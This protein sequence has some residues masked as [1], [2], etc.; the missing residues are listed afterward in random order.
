MNMHGII[1]PVELGAPTRVPWGRRALAWFHDAHWQGPR[2]GPETILEVG[3]V[4]EPGRKY[5]VRAAS[6]PGAPRPAAE[7]SQL[8]DRSVGALDPTR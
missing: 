1:E 5:R 3:L 7:Q 6:V 2:P 8:F 4:S